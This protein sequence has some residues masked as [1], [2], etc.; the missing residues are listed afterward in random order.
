M[1]FAGNIL[2]SA[3]G[4]HVYY[5]DLT[6]NRLMRSIPLH[7]KTI[8]SVIISSAQHNKSTLLISGSLDGFVK[9]K[10]RILFKILVT[11]KFTIMVCLLQIS[12]F[13]DCR[14]LSG[15]RYSSPVLSCD[16][17]SDGH[18]LGVGMSDGM[19]SVKQRRR[20]SH[21]ISNKEL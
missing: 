4:T 10:S 8:T 16:L 7:Q 12:D 6:A 18:A 15:L 19:L 9:V 3:A 14:L 21:A 2:V 5:W 17:A 20:E 11:A 1:I 13:E